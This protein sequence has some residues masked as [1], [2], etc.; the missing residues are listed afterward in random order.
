MAPVHEGR[1]PIQMG[2]EKGGSLLRGIGPQRQVAREDR[3]APSGKQQEDHRDQ[4]P[5]D[6]VPSSYG[7]P[8]CVLLYVNTRIFVPFHAPVV[9]PPRQTQK[10]PVWTSIHGE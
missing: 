4:P 8:V 2:A 9:P 1:A 7:V 3:C 5:C 6:E 10:F